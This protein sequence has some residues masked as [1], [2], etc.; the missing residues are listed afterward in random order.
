MDVIDALLMGLLQGLTEYLPVSSS[1]H[2]GIASHFFGIEG[3]A[4]LT[5][6]VAVHVATVFRHFGD[7]LERYRVDIQGV[8]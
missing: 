6:T 4:N 2:L 7:S 3:E 1:G 8:V 5:F